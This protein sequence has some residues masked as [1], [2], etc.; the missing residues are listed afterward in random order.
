MSESDPPL[1]GWTLGSN[2]ASQQ[3]GETLPHSDRGTVR[4]DREG[5]VLGSFLSRGLC[6]GGRREAQDSHARSVSAGRLSPA[7]TLWEAALLLE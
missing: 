3:P 2:T 6:R 7:R 5:L 1:V 4:G